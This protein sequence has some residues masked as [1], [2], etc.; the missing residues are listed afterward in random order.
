MRILPGPSRFN[1]L[2]NFGVRVV[3]V[4]LPG[5]PENDRIAGVK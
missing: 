5:D 4:F 1:N 2:N 3:S